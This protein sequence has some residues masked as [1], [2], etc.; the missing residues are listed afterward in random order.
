MKKNAT[1]DHDGRS[2]TQQDISSGRYMASE[3]AWIVLR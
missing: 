3:P 2:T 1:E